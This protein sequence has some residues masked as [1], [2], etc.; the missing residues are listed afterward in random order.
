MRQAQHPR[1]L[2]LNR[3]PRSDTHQIRLALRSRP[4]PN[5]I[6]DRYPIVPILAC[7]FALIAFPLLNY[8]TPLDS[9][10]IRDGVA[11][12]ETRIFWPMMA[13][14]SIMLVVRNRLRLSKLIWPSHIVCLLVYTSFAGASVLWAFSLESSFVRFVQQVMIVTSIILPAMLAHRTADMMR[15]LFLCF[16][17]ASILNIFF[18]IYGDVDTI[19]CSATNFCHQGYFGG[20]N[21]L[22]E[23]AAVT[24]LL[25]FLEIFRRGGGRCVFGIIVGAL[26]IVL[27]FL[28][29][30]KTALGLIIICPLLSQLTLTVRKITRISVAI[31]LLSIPLCYIVAT[32]VSGVDILNRI[33]YIVYHDSS[34][35]GRTVIWDF[36]QTQIARKPLLGW[37]YQSFW[38]VPG[39]PSGQAVG[40]VKLM[41]NAHNGYYDTTVELGYVGLVFLYVFIITTL[42]GIGRVADR[43]PTRARLLLSVILFF[44]MWNYFE[45]LWM[46][47]FEFLW[48]VFLIVSAEIARYWQIV[49]PEAA[50]F[51]VKSLRPGGAGVFTMRAAPKPLAMGAD[52]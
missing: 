11:R 24:F 10:A 13:A 29:D 32:I 33:A 28:S 38:L 48:I 39:S 44:I 9:V 25:S 23:C 17:L 31:I 52:R 22:G 47:G 20:K 12:P 19:N 14:V 50:T 1:T 46:R 27:V 30:S 21:Y 5:A 37:G 34:L 49:P 18:I 43:D 6:I 51:R 26:A 15:G 7:A 3:A 36:V 16:A 4:T 40:W 45:S 2:E 42:H 8:L 41:P 35:T